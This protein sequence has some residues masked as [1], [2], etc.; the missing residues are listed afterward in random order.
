MMEPLLTVD[1]IAKYLRV[2]PSTIYQWTHQGFIPHIK[3]GNLVR[4]RI[5]QVDK[6]L[7]GKANNGRFSRKVNSL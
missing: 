3:I 5:S 1:E 6:W 4:F 2:Q 7:E